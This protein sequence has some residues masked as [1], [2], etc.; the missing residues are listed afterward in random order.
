MCTISGVKKGPLA[1]YLL[2]LYKNGALI[3]CTCYAKTLFAES[4]LNFSCYLGNFLWLEVN[5]FHFVNCL[6][7]VDL[8]FF[9]YT[10]KLLMASF[11]SFAHNF[12]FVLKNI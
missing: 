3:F 8:I 4:K 9:V 7:L 10:L 2:T 5:S 1:L 6:K 12:C 11:G